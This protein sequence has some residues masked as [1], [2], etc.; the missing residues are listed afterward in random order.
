[1]FLNIEV[2]KANRTNYSQILEKIQDSE[3]SEDLKETL[4][5]RL[6]RRPLDSIEQTN[7]EEDR[8]EDELT[9]NDNLF[10]M[11][12][13]DKDTEGVKK[14]LES[15]GFEDLG[16]EK[17]QTKIQLG[18]DVREK[19]GALKANLDL[20]IR[21]DDD[22]QRLLKLYNDARRLLRGDVDE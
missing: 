8:I 5:Y 18:R 16:K 14:G 7:D 3:L 10:K 12:D 1:M 20:E 9:E 22:Y 13:D 19:I 6:E 11:F 2:M 21:N 15:E 17:E 4:I